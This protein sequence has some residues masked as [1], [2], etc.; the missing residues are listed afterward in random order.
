M[1][2]QISRPKGCI[3]TLVA[4]LNRP[5]N[6]NA[7]FAMINFHHFLQVDAPSFAASVQLT[8]KLKINF[9]KQ[10][11]T[12]AASFSWRTSVQLSNHKQMI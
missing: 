12:F 2:S 5:T 7:I 3:F 6:T 9:K 1:H 11:W 4:F 8:K 10:V